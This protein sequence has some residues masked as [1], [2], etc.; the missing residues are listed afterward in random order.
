MTSLESS[1][2]GEKR[3]GAIRLGSRPPAKESNW[4]WRR[5]SA[6]GLAIVTGIGIVSHFGH[7]RI[8]YGYHRPGSD[9]RTSSI[10]PDGW[11]EWS[12]ITPSDKLI[13]QPCFAVYGG[14]FQC[15]RLTVPMDYHRPLSESKDNPK[16]H[17]ALILKP[18]INRTDD[19]SS[20]SESPLLLNPGGPGG[21]GV[22]FSLTAAQ[23]LQ[24][25]VGQDRD[26]IGFDPRGVGSTTPKADCFAAIDGPFD[27]DERNIALMNRLSWD[28][29][30]HDVGL[31]NSSNVAL[32]KLD[33]RSRALSKLCKRIDEA[34]GEN[35]IFRYSN[36]LNVAR[37]MLSIVDAWDQW[38]S[39]SDDKRA[40]CMQ[41]SKTDDEPQDSTKGKLVYWG[42]SY[43]TLLGATFASLF[44]DRVGR[45]VLDGVV[46]ADHYVNA[47]F[48]AVVDADKIWEKFFVY[49]AEAGPQCDFFQLGDRPEDVKKRFYDTMAQLEKEPAIVLPLHANVPVLVT[50]SDFK[51][52]IFSAIYAPNGGF[53]NLAKLLKALV[54]GKLDAFVASPTPALL[55]HN[56]TLPVWPDDAQKVIACSDKRYK[57]DEDIPS[58]QKR[59]EKMASHSWFADLW[60]GVNLNLG[61]N[62]WD[63]ETKDPP[64]RWDDH[65]IHKP[66]P[67][68]TSFPVL[69][70]S[71]H[72][73]PV[74]PLHAALKMT[75][76][77]SNASIVEQKAEGHCT[78]ACVS[79]CTINHI[80]A[81]FDK[82]VVP[83]KPKFDSDDEG[84]WPTC[85][86]D[87]KPW[88][89]LSGRASMASPGSDPRS[90]GDY[91]LLHGKTAEEVEVMMAYHDLRDQFVKFPMFHDQFEHHN[92]LRGAHLSSSIFSI[93]EQHT[94]GKS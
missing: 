91:E 82:G 67:I 28:A 93:R 86:C 44:P 42:F 11:T 55:C 69:F 73:D 64:M 23:K 51:R 20:Y 62:G 59:F 29:S 1:L 24:T 17:I 58:L 46:D 32:S 49:C 14:N 22:I 77:F 18:G 75:R 37:D 15:A 65:P 57:L 13:W 76:K 72:L 16:V 2:L 5:L 21:S 41:E 53:P 38:R 43:G 39:T 87:E 63:I 8:Y 19:P 71:N 9:N 56:L 3:D 48:D 54:D 4:T 35:S 66:K 84:E 50:A 34:D 92:P 78:L 70:L 90:Q 7:G 89:S 45:V 81:Y 47:V 52:I 74:T 94:C 31:V 60:M 10:T 26:V 85:D 36:T 83:P 88:K 12:N 25:I 33:V 40:N 79:L 30:G 6:I 68:N 27:L 80:R 61:C